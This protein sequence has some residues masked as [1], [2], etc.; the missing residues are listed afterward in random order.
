MK[1]PDRKINKETVDLN[2]TVDQMD[3]TDTYRSSHPR[4]LYICSRKVHSLLKLTW[5]ILQDRILLDHKMSFPHMLV[6]R[7]T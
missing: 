6:F 7:I 1:H 3:L 5:N 2:N 4:S